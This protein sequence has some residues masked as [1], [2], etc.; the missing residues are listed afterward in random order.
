MEGEKGN[1][2][3]VGET[4][5][6]KTTPSSDVIKRRLSIKQRDDW[7]QLRRSLQHNKGSGEQHH[8]KK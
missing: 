6:G 7:L 5:C 3:V 8:E 4:G 1:F 2:M